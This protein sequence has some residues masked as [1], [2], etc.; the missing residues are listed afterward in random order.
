MLVGRDVFEGLHMK[1]QSAPLL[2]R[3]CELKT[4]VIYLVCFPIW[5]WTW[6]DKQWLFVIWD[7]GV[8]GGRQQLYRYFAA[9]RERKGWRRG[10]ERKRSLEHRNASEEK[11]LRE[12]NEGGYSRRGATCTQPTSEPAVTQNKSICSVKYLL[13]SISLV[14]AWVLR[15]QISCHRCF[16]EWQAA[17]YV[18]ISWNNEGLKHFF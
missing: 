3:Y 18:C 10:R 16:F 17:I 6:N 11:R 9:G 5:L 4:S 13:I 14:S 1:C 2:L 15:L 7:W 8:G 12:F